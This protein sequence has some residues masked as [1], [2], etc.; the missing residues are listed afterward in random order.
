MVY[1]S[2]SAILEHMVKKNIFFVGIGIVVLLVLALVV[3]P[4]V[5]F[6]GSIGRVNQ[7]IA[8]YEK[9]GVAS[10][11]AELNDPTKSLDGDKYVFVFRKSD[12]VIVVNPARKEFVGQ[13][14]QD[15][16]D[17]SGYNYG[18]EIY[19]SAQEGEESVEYKILNPVTKKE[20]EKK[21]VITLHDGYF[22]GSGVYQ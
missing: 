1:F 10:A 16:N 3:T 13:R 2:I 15:L 7:A 11:F 21:S 4:Y 12:G 22:F 6:S 17:D 19:N 9:L 5:H 18:R 14:V 8:L 20:Q